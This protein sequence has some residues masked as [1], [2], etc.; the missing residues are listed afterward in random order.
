MIDGQCGKKYCTT[1]LNFNFALVKII[2]IYVISALMKLD[3]DL[4]FSFSS[5]LLVHDSVYNS[6]GNLSIPIASKNGIFLPYPHSRIYC[7]VILTTTNISHSF[8]GHSF[9]SGI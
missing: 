9:S 5:H 4:L 1:N 2:Y 8:W 3:Q 6:V 7:F